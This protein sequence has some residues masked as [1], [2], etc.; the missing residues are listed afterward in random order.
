M[1]HKW[2]GLKSFKRLLIDP[3]I[4]KYVHLPTKK[5]LFV[6]MLQKQR[7]KGSQKAKKM[8]MKIQ[9]KRRWKFDHMWHN[10]LAGGILRAAVHQIVTARAART[11]WRE[12]TQ[13]VIS[14]EKEELA[15]LYLFLRF[16]LHFHRSRGSIMPL[17]RPRHVLSFSSEDVVSLFRPLWRNT[18]FSLCSYLSAAVSFVLRQTN[19]EIYII[20]GLKCVFTYMQC[21]R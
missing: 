18:T 1:P 4:Q 20:I 3:K 8:E 19:E 2:S 11:K 14:F 7:I 16:L 6:A 10:L 9:I 12:I 21:S 15:L 17:I 13:A 5:R